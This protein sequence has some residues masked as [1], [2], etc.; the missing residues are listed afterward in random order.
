MS[1]KVARV[2]DA[3]AN[4]VWHWLTDTRQWPRWGPSV[5]EVECAERHIRHGSTG[6]V[7]TVLGLWAPFTIT[8]FDD[9]RYWSWRVYGLPATG[10][11]L[12][13]LGPGRCRLTFEIPAMAA[14]YAAVCKIALARIAHLNR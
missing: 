10:H 4:Q 7:R 2:I 11:R 3:P 5:R 13:A 8:D 6:R 9:G 14:P 1:V 12:E